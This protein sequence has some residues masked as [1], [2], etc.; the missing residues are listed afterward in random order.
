[1]VTDLIRL[2]T[3]SFDKDAVSQFCSDGVT[4]ISGGGNYSS[5]AFFVSRLILAKKDVKNT[6]W[7]V[8]NHQE[9]EQICAAM[10]AWGSFNVRFL[11]I[12][13][14]EYLDDDT[15]RKNKIKTSYFLSEACLK[16]G[17]VFVMEYKDA[18]A[19]YP[20][21]ESIAGKIFSLRKS[22]SADA[23]TIF[24]KLID[25]GYEVSS[26]KRIE[27]GQYYKSGEILLLH[28]VNL[29]KPVQ[30]EV[31]F[32][33][34][35]KISSYD[36]DTKEVGAK[37]DELAIFPTGDTENKSSIFDY[38]QK[39]S[40]IVDDDLEI[41]DEEAALYD[42]AQ[43]MADPSTYKVNFTSF[44]EESAYH[45]HLHYLS[46]LRYQ[47]VLDFIADVKEKIAMDWKIALFTKNLA[48]Y[49]GAFEDKEVKYH[50]VENG[51]GLQQYRVN[52]V[53]IDKND[54]FP[55]PFQNPK[56]K[57]VTVTDK[58]VVDL[59]ESK[60][61]EDAKYRVF[62]DFLTGLKVND[63]VVHTDH[64]IGLFMGLDKKTVDGVTREY[65]KIGYAENDKL[66]VP[67]DQADKVSKFIGAGDQP[68]RL[69]R[70][71]SA[72]WATLTSKVK[73]ETEKIAKELLELYAKRNQ[74]KGHTFRD[75]DPTQEQFEKTFPYEETPGQIRA[76]HDVK[77]DMEREKPMDRLVCGDVGFGKTE[78]AMR[79]AF[80]AVKGG[81]QVALVSPITILADQ[82]YKSFKKRMDEF[83]VRIE[84]L[85]RF[86]SQGE[87]KKILRDIANGAVDIIIGTHRIL[88][89]DVH[90]K[91]L[92]LV[93][94]DEEQ[95]FGVKQKEKLKELRTEVDILTL[96]AT[97]IPRTLNISLNGLRDI[98]TITT[99]PPG[100]LPIIT[101]VRRFGYNLIRMAILEEKARGGQVYFLH[102]RVQ[103]IE[104]M[105]DKLRSLVPEAKFVVT[106]GKL[107][108]SELESRIMA[109]KDGEFDV[110]VSSTIIENGIDLPNAN[111][112]IVN[113]A[114][115]FG[116][117]QLYQL[118]GRVGRSRRQAYA[119]F[120]YTQQKLPLDAKKR[121]RAIVE[122]SELGSGFQI[123]MKDLEIRGAGDILGVSQHGSINVVGVSH[124][125]RMLNQ[126]VEAL[127]DGVVTE[128][129]ERP[130]EVSIELPLPA[131]IP[132]DYVVNFRDKINVYQ[133]LAGADNM[134]YLGELKVEV[135]NDYGRMPSEVLNL[136]K[137]L[138]LKLLAKKAN[139][140]NVRA[141]S[142]HSDVERQIVLTMSDKVKPEN[143]MNL[144]EYNPKW[145]I[146]GTKL[147]CKI[148]NLG[149]HWTDELA[150]C[151]KKLAGKVE[152]G[153]WIRE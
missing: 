146:S 31:G 38:F 78:V 70:L 40:L 88:Q 152:R 129:E 12:E 74:A 135:T 46:V 75:D 121:L 35:E 77:L 14:N 98:T 58:E 6:L 125:I 49:K 103:T 90:F 64:G 93:I 85:S 47:N 147:K 68:P 33:K 120:L 8:S 15:E 66:F 108:S 97:P 137:I 83:N 5:K 9:K 54:P 50:I 3:D 149:V 81:K 60:K 16:S 67:I 34:V 92:G 19:L 142:V 11:D 145:I 21:P 76:I 29:E 151:F 89:P 55:V 111:T 112:L 52:I 143:I 123:A 113:N 39:G 51:S 30:I 69:T 101:E 150:E 61:A 1:M 26:D 118:R 2:F 140:T 116:L 102:N 7:I 153:K 119:F 91:D 79:A 110:L 114:E 25:I 37:I 84:M 99:P 80:K 132:D 100:R 48:E 72:E 115:R 73:K 4:T 133:K 138:E 13:K 18:L 139:L 136:F 82:H 27:K 87:Q 128:A 144:L 57:V 117:A 22:D 36:L 43:K 23:V 141:E 59:K 41:P 106:H 134:T 71:G 94:I 127:K 124:F 42:E 45:H 130:I 20:K 53:L 96:T 28:P 126:A 148:A 32:N 17:G 65:L 104:D 122:A 86:R 56:I 63:Y 107:G 10:T 105:A 95:R 24:N 131:L 44:M 109:F 62:S